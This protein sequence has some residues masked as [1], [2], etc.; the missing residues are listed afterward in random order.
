MTYDQ[1]LASLFIVTVPI[2]FEDL[3]QYA[4]DDKLCYN[5]FERKPPAL[6][7]LRP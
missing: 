4:A 6:S 7:F 3:M 2:V 1:M 5:C